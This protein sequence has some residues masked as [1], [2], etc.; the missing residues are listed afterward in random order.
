MGLVFFAK[1]GDNKGMNSRTFLYSFLISA[2]F[3]PVFVFAESDLEQTCSQIIEK[4]DPCQG[5]TSS[6][7]QT[8][9]KNCAAFY[10]QES[11]K[12]AEDITKTEAEKKTL[13]NKITT[14]KKKVQNLDYQIK[15]GKVVIKD[16]ILQIEDTQSSIN[17]ITLQIEESKDQIINVLRTIDEEYQKSSVEILFEGDLSDF[18]NNLAY[19]DSLNTK[20][21]NLLESTKDLKSYLEGQKTNMDSEKTGVEK[22]VKL[23]ALQKQESEST[24][25]EQESLLKLTEAQYQEQLQAKQD[26][27]KKVAAI[28][29]RIFELIG[30]SKAPTFGEAYAIAKYVSDITGVRTAFLLAVLTQ[31]SNIGKNVGQCYVT[32]LSTG[33]GTDL[34]GNPKSRVMNPKYISSFTNLTTL[35]GMDPVKTSVSCWIPLYTRG[36]PYGWGGA[37]GPAQFTASTW[38]LYKDKVAQITGKTANPWNIKDAFLAAGL[39]LKDDGALKNEFTAAMRYFSGGSWTRSEEFYGRSVLA[40]AKGYADDIAAIEG[41]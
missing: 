34:K 22:T 33:A 30:V 26:A 4:S 3:L 29:A 37:M 19:L 13:Q 9:L 32:N 25:K 16:L 23:Q 2:L 36:V 1:R 35:L 5:M 20:L 10:E 31:E 21:R 8:M 40:I 14:L 12:I 28:N 41:Q 6:N 17:K 39:L 11:D 18:F 38:N 24:K 27:D 7:C 15:Q